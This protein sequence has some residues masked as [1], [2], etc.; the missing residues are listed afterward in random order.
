M[1]GRCRC[2]GRGP[3]P[4]RHR[5]PDYGLDITRAD[6]SRAT[7]GQVSVRDL[8]THVKH[9]LS[10]IDAA[11][12]AGIDE[13]MKAKHRLRL[14][15]HGWSWV[16]DQAADP[17]DGHS[18]WTPGVPV[19]EGN[20]VEV[21][22]DGEHIVPRITELLRGARSHVHMTSWHATPDFAMD[23]EATLTLR[24]LL[25]E[26]AARVPTR[27]LM[28]AGAPVPVFPPARAHVRTDAR[29]F[30]RDSRL[31]LALD[32]RERPMHCHHEK[33]TIVDDEV[34]VVGGLDLTTIEGNRF[35]GA[36]HPKVGELG[37]HDAAFVVRGPVVADIAGHFTHRWLEITGERLP[38]PVP[39]Q[40]TG[41]VAL[42]M[43]RT[44]PNSVYDFCPDGEYTGLAAYL[45]ALRG[46]QHLV[47]LENQFLWSPEVVDVLLDKLQ[48]PPNPDFRVLMVLPRKPSSGEDTTSG[49]LARLIAADAGR[50]NLLAVT[51]LGPTEQ[52]AGVYVHAKV[53]II[54]DRWL[55]IGSTNL[56]EHSLCNDSEM[57][58]LTLDPELARG[59][60]LRL[61]SEH[62]RVPVSE[63]TGTPA[64]LI[65]TLW[66][67]QCNEQDQ[68]SRR[69]GD[70]VHRIRR[71]SGLS[72]RRSRLLGPL[73][74][75]VVD[76]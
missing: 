29:E 55:T 45:R 42:Q 35:D 27:M 25:A 1:V 38:D 15:R 69:G 5:R 44:I 50:G 57:N 33:I 68:V 30:C 73:T 37:W 4:V 31:H 43:L 63:L 71:L 41:D 49:Q 2:G 13:A 56:N 47:Y 58:L 17:T 7:V 14:A 76:G 39:Q 26:T 40:P 72:R 28:W 12:G 64:S 20:S 74:G 65:D 18:W 21:L 32:R 67:T 34:A 48:D 24:D 75:L 9:P 22:L 51:L 46:A 66:T 19:R 59:T 23:A 54:D 11:L 52:S 53:G 10:G 61:W 36:D 60:R 3:Q 62:L 16:L 70:P 8:R 6:P